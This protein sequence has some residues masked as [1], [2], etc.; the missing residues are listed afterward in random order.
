MKP[1]IA[2]CLLMAQSAFAAGEAS[3]SVAVRHVGEDNLG[4][5]LTYAIREQIRASRGF[6][7]IDGPTAEYRIS[8]VTLEPESD[9]E[10]KGHRTIVSYTFSAKNTNEYRDGSPQTWYSL[11][12][13]SGISI[14][15]AKKIA[16]QA[17]DIL[18]A[19][20]ESVRDFESDKRK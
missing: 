16:E 7:L 15:G 11:Y 6:T 20:D 3:H 2:A 18:A 8:L 5:Q 1:S 9:Q 14:V 12:I 17:T 4:N 13:T 10:R 19:L